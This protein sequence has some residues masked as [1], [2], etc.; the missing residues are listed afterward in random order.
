MS[1]NMM[2][3]RQI[4]DLVLDQMTQKKTDAEIASALVSAGMAAADAAN[5]IACVR[6]GFQAGTVAVVTN[7]IS[8]QDGRMNN[9]PIFTIAF[10]KGKVAC[11]HSMY[12]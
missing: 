1:G 9:N 6:M 3:E 2:T 12:Q 11:P 10:K 7:G 4:V 5:V 8:A